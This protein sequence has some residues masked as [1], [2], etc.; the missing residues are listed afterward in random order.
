MKTTS[1]LCLHVVISTLL[2]SCATPS[3]I[4]HAGHIHHSEASTSL[5]QQ[6][7]Q[8]FSQM[9]QQK[10]I[11]SNESYNAQLQRVGRRLLKVIPTK[12][13]NWEFVVFQDPTPNAFALPG[14]KVGVHTGLFQITQDDAGLAA[15]V[16]HEIAHVTANHAGK[17]I[18]QAQGISIGSA[19]LDGILGAQGVSSSTRNTAGT[20]Y[21]TGTKLGAALP[22]SRGQ[23]SEADKIGMIYMA[24]AG[25]DPVQAINMWK[26]FA[27][28]NARQGS[29]TPEFLRTH[30]LN[31]TRIRQLEAFLP[32]A[33]QDY[34]R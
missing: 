6:G 34:R 10:K 24:K 32:R 33:Q 30:P 21:N 22:F 7:Q 1:L 2:F 11:S 12:T 26:R 17:R 16:G 19:I 8:A 27:A 23:E 14:G 3:A 20:I 4:D 29:E 15:V 9:K 25:Y 28:Y 31:N 5:Q 13:P 18:K